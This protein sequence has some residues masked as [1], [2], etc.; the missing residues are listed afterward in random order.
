M[1]PYFYYTLPV[2]FYCLQNPS[3]STIPVPRRHAILGTSFC[4]KCNSK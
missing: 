2:L 3:I 1:T 4:G